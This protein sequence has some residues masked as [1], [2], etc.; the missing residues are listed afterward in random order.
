MTILC[1]GELIRSAIADIG[2][3]ITV[4][5]VTVTGFNE[6]GDSTKEST[7]DT[8]VTVV[9]SQMIDNEDIVKEGEFVS[10]DLK[11]Y[12]KPVDSEYAVVGN[13]ILRGTRWFKIKRVVE[14]FPTYYTD[15]VAGRI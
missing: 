5:S 2:E 10:G 1:D 7:T 15:V 14:G 13:R 3:V 4:R 12:F 11:V 6:W 8:S 9:F